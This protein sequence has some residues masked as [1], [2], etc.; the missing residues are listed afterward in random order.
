MGGSIEGQTFNLSLST[1]ETCACMA[2]EGYV[3]NR[4]RVNHGLG[5]NS[6]RAVGAIV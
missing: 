1:N 2:C 3:R 4:R 5:D 6:N